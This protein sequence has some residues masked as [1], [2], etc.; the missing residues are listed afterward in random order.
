MTIEAIQL[1]EHTKRLLMQFN[2]LRSEPWENDAQT[3]SLKDVVEIF[4]YMANELGANP[5]N[6]PGVH[7][8]RQAASI[9]KEMHSL[10]PFLSTALLQDVVSSLGK[11]RNPSPQAK[12][13]GYWIVFGLISLLGAAVSGCEGFDLMSTILSTFSV[14]S[15]YVLVCS[16]GLSL[17][18][19]AMFY[20]LNLLYVAHVLGLNIVASTKLLDNALTEI[21]LIGALRRNLSQQLVCASAEDKVVIQ[22]MMSQLA[23]QIQEINKA[24]TS[25]NDMANNPWFILLKHLIAAIAAFLFFCSGFCAGQTASMFILTLC[26]GSVVTPTFW[27]VLLVSVL[28][29]LLTMG[30]YSLT[31][32]DG[33]TQVVSGWFGLDA[34]KMDQLNHL[35]E[36]EQDEMKTF[37][38]RFFSAK[39]EPK[40]DEPILPEWFLQTV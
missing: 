11:T 24:R 39:P 19:I 20:T 28:M 18:S 7:T 35:V 9:P 16:L 17:V 5:L 32:H 25:F 3:L 22:R 26:L 21:Q 12:S 27:P 30:L 38:V 31:Q 14:P 23:V 6:L 15:I 29:G 37:D 40:D 2:R 33:F 4:E 34:G 1:S 13:R 36:T 8:P 10:F